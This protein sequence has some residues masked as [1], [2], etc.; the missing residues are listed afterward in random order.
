[1]I[2]I[3]K[4]EKVFIKNQQHKIKLDYTKC[5]KFINNNDKNKT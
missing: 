5:S 4:E 1:M 2:D 3:I